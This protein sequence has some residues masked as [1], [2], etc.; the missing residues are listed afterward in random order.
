[1]TQQ[2]KDYGPYPFTFDIECA[3][4]KNHYYRKVIWTG[5]HLQLALMS[6]PVGGEIG[7][8]IHPDT[9][10]FFRIEGGR[11]IV[12]MGKKRNDLDYRRQVR[13]GDAVL[14]PANTWHNILNTG[15]ESLKVYTIYAPPHH[16]PGTIH[17]TKAQAEAEHD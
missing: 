13:S 3:T 4:M 14:V 7:L 5:H 9:D 15:N 8:E 16:P 11:G 1:M 6:I 17:K 2:R 10:Q 12:K